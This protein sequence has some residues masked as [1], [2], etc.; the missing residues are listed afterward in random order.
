MIPRTD[1]NL[2]ATDAR[3][4]QPE[5]GEKVIRISLHGVASIGLFDPRV[6][7][8]W[9]PLPT[10]QEK[11]KQWIHEAHPNLTLPIRRNG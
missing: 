2:K 3:D 6:H 5:P 9:L 4:A 1:K 11:T 10:L 8:A 7:V